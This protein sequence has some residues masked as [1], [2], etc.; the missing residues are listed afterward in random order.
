MGYGELNVNYVVV[1]EQLNVSDG[2]IIINNN[3]NN[4]N[5][6]SKNNSDIRYLILSLFF[7]LLNLVPYVSFCS[8]YVVIDAFIVFLFCVYLCLYSIPNIYMKKSTLGILFQMIWLLVCFYFIFCI[9]VYFFL[10]IYIFYWKYIN[11]A[12]K[13]FHNLYKCTKKNY[14]K[15]EKTN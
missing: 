13:I 6:N 5:H 2:N 7:F 1:K 14:V 9:C 11:R 3:Y 8:C 10:F 12:K 4:N 15:Y